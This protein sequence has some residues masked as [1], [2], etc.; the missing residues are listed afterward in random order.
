M[1]IVDA[2]R[3]TAGQRGMTDLEKIELACLRLEERLK[4]LAR[5]HSDAQLFRMFAEEIRKVMDKKE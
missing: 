4:A 1:D 5:F 3:R 2:S